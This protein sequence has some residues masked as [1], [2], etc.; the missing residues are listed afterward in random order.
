M[1]VLRALVVVALLV[2]L[3]TVPAVAQAG[4]GLTTPYPAVAVEPGETTTFPLTV[5]APDGTRV[6]L[7]VTQLPDGW[8]AT[9]RGGGFV[10]DAVIVDADNPPDVTLEVDVPAGT[11]EGD[12]DVVVTASAGNTVTLPLDL[13]V[14][15]TAGGAVTLTAEF[16]SLEGAS[17]ATFTFDVT[18]ANDTPEETTFSLTAEGP[19]GWIVDA[20]PAGEAQAA[21][22]TVGGGGTQSVTVSVDPPDDV[23]A[24]TYP[25]VVRA[26]GGGQ[27]AS[28]E[29]AVEITGSFALSLVPP[30]ERLNATV[31]AG[32]ATDVALLVVNDGTAPLVGVQLSASP[33]ADWEVIFTPEVV[34]QVPPGESVD[35]VAT[36]RPAGNA[37]AGD[38]SV[39]LTARVPETSDTIELR[40]TV[41]TAQIWGLVGI[42]LIA[43]ALGGLAW[44]FRRFGRR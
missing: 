21:T 15:A 20:R 14:T 29:L 32:G 26:V 44:V 3:A 42:A 11:A 13:R 37:V 33:P 27:T 12:Y 2:V 18:L 22:A 35:V 10:V 17:D 5:S 28:A 4:L 43:L 23:A 38:Y 1:P 40:T 25:I 34:D 24:G 6:N 7:A 8:S 31:E 39:G 16:P 9:L 41:E 30:D 36:I 19:P